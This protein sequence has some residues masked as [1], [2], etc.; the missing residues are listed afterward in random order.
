MKRAGIAVAALA[1]SAC[2]TVGAVDADP[3]VL[4]TSGKLAGVAEGNAVVFRGVPYA[5]PPVGDLR[6]RAPEP[7]TWTAE[8]AA[9]ALAEKSKDA[10]ASVAH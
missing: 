6:W 5:Q 10:G 9:E 2:V 7:I 1:L 3:I 4:T 8:M